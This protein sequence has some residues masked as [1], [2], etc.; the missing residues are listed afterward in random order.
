MNV[1][2]HIVSNKDD[3]FDVHMLKLFIELRCKR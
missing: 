3:G 2:S 1:Y